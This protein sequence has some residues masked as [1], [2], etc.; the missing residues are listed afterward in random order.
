MT[1]DIELDVK[2]EC[3]KTE[4]DGSKVWQFRAIHPTRTGNGRI[5]TESELIL[6]ARGLAFRPLN[7]DHNRVDG[8]LP[9]RNESD[10][11]YKNSTLVAD[12]DEE[13]KAVVGL[14][15]IEDPNVNQMIES[16]LIK[17]VSIEQIPYQ[18]EDC[19]MT[20]CL[21]KGV[22]IIG[23][24]LLQNIPAG[25]KTS[26]IKRFEKIESI[27]EQLDKKI[28]GESLETITNNS[29]DSS[30]KTVCQCPNKDMTSETI[31]EKTNEETVK[32]ESTQPKTTPEVKTEGVM[33]IEDFSKF[34]TQSQKQHDESLKLIADQIGLLIPKQKEEASSLVAD[35]PVTYFESAIQPA[36]KWFNDIRA[37]KATSDFFSWQVPKE[38]MLKG[39]GLKSPTPLDQVKVEGI[40][41]TDGDKPITVDNKV[42][43]LPNG[44]M[45]YSIRPYCD[46]Q[47]LNNARTFQWWTGTGFDVD[48]TT[49]E[50][51]EP[52]NESQTIAKVTVTPAIYR[53]VQTIEVG[54]IEE[55]NVDLIDYFNRSAIKGA[56]NVE[57]TAI[58]TTLLDAQTPDGTNS[59]KLAWINANDGTDLS[60]GATDDVASMTFDPKCFTKALSILASRGF[61]TSRGN[62]VAFLHPTAIQ[63][64]ADAVDGDYSTKDFSVAHNDITKY[65][66]M[67]YGIEIVPASKV[68]AKDNTTNDTYR[69]YIMVRGAVGLGIGSNLTIE[70]QKKVELSAVKV[71]ARHKVAGAVL[72][73]GGIVRASSKQ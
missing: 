1:S 22:T 7:L 63:Q 15:R 31:T 18:G 58:L 46:V 2:L 24:G 13:E 39:L 43:I 29:Q 57:N 3:V 16:G 37:E 21:Q 41:I 23:L 14:M 67:R 40:T 28:S 62:V 10:G 47:V 9:Y 71:G 33:K 55:M 30:V 42:I 68:K 19:N 6:S 38:E 56:I 5:Y 45:V 65:V 44:E 59:T 61:D 53:S 26:Y 66:E 36:S 32:T 17:Q 27:L 34:L 4:A 64:L 12:W 48:D 8:W 25:D 50:G 20:S 49:A 73:A 54:D 60:A 69:N 35:V 52:T 51:T 11:S 72:L 70:A